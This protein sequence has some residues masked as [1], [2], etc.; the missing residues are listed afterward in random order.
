MPTSPTPRARRSRSGRTGRCL[1]LAA[2]FAV[3]ASAGATEPTGA[4]AGGAG[5]PPAPAPPAAF[6]GTAFAR[7]LAIADL[8]GVEPPPPGPAPTA[9]GLGARSGPAKRELPGG[10]VV[11]TRCGDGWCV[12]GLS[13]RGKVLVAPK[14]TADE[15]RWL[16]NGSLERV[17]R[18]DWW[19]DAFVSAYVAETSFEAGA[20]HANDAL[21]C[22]TFDARSGRT[23]TL[24]DVLPPRFAALVLAKARRLLADE[25]LAIDEVGEAL[26]SGGGYELSPKDFRL[27]RT[28]GYTGSRPEIVLCAEGAWQSVGGTILELRLE[29]MPLTY[30]LGSG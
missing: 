28:P 3:A 13:V 17:V 11:E 9:A 14:P 2:A 24:G 29:A 25:N 20:A 26:S 23:L 22:R 21:R 10:I 30:L 18:V 12:D 8:E 19:D 5:R 4:T 7:R 6:G 16:R 1:A 27:A 15:A